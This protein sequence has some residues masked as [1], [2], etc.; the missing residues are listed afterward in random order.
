MDVL[1]SHTGSW[2]GTNRFRLMPT[3]EPYAAAATAQLD[4]GARG[5]LAVVRYTWTHEEAGPQDG[6]LVIGRQETA[7]AAVALWGDSWHQAPAA[8]SLSGAA[9]DTGVTLGYA[10]GDGWQW[11][12]VLDVTD[13]RLLRLR[14]D[15]VVP[16]SAVP[17]GEPLAYWAMDAELHRTGV[18]PEPD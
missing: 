16:A 1:R 12:V 2:T 5:T 11:R 9:D 7:G 8:A 17:G 10:Y 18:G 13:P 6:L 4:L 3:D 15:N 14:M